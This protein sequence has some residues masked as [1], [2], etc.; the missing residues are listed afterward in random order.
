MSTRA[1]TF[2]IM[3]HIA[4]AMQNNGDISVC[5]ICKTVLNIDGQPSRIDNHKISDF[6]NSPDR[7][8]II[9]D[10]D[11]GIKHPGCAACWSMESSNKI[12]NRQ[13]FNASFEDKGHT[14][15]PR[16]LIMKPGNTCNLA[17][18]TCSPETS[19]SLYSDSYKLFAEKNSGVSFNQYIK[20][21]E[22]VRNSFSEDNPNFWPI[23]NDWYDGLEFIDIYGGEP[24]LINGLW[25]SLTHAVGTG[26]SKHISLQL[27]TNCMIWND[28]H[29]DILSEFKSVSIG[30]SIDSH[31]DHELAYIRHKSDHS[32][33]FT[34]CDKFIDFA[35]K[36]DNM[37]CNI[38]VTVSLLN[39]WN[40]DEIAQG[41][42]QRFN[43]KV[44][45]SNFVFTPPH[46]DIRHLP[47][48]VKKQ[49][50]DKF[51][52]TEFEAVSSY[53]NNH[54]QGC[55]IYWPRF[56]MMTDRF[57]NIR[58]QRFADVFPQ[59]HAILEPY[60]DYKKRHPEWY[61]TVRS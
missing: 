1:D 60:W 38:A 34:N 32:K 5:N 31:L 55:D 43:V 50:M 18:R 4:L 56:C 49:V 16:V 35:N 45:F 3:P 51:S 2:C 57:D 14:D 11:N 6:W 15:S 29:M 10:L 20:G 61:G 7:Q 44:G 22:S 54:V 41:L 39:V 52:G 46:Y 37:K 42:R 58:N 19:S 59:W 23:V 30:L 27:H 48:E 53:M 28:E 24:W 25:K 33:V 13:S 40:I 26:S 17:C 8:A 21:F 47:L 36:T 12:S 9:D